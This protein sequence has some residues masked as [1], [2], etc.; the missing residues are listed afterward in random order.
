VVEPRPLWLDV[1]APEPSAAQSGALSLLEVRGRAGT[2]ARAPVDL[3]IVVDLSESTLYP[4]GSDV[5]GDGLLGVMSE[6][7]TH[8][9]TGASRPHWLWTTDPG[10]TIASAELAAAQRLVQRLDADRTQVGLVTFA[11]R[12]QVIESVGSVAQARS[13]LETLR[14]RLDT[15]GTN[16]GGAIHTALALLARTQRSSTEPRHQMI[17][18]LSDGMPTIPYP[19][20]NARRYAIEAAE[21]ARDSGVRI[22]TL[23]LADDEGA[24]VLASM[25]RVSRGLH[26]PVSRMGEVVQQLPFTGLAGVESVSISNRTTGADGRAVRLFADGSFDGFVSLVPGNN[27]LQ[28]SVRAASGAE[29]H[30]QRTVQYEP[31]PYGALDQER[32][33]ALRSKL[34]ERTIE[35]ELAARA[36]V[37]DRRVRIEVEP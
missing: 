34:R 1:F 26:I 4:S 6:R 31:M 5:D 3:V 20:V 21:R 22:H 14:P 33:E 2:G 25:A 30:E 13:R 27:V 17:L 36:R 37:G 16:L 32:A 35:T 8:N 9:A 28:V 10:D 23:A 7:G 15:S 19:E 18:V 12:A 29:V 24:D 11:G